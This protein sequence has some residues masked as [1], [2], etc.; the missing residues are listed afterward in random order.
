MLFAFSPLFSSNYILQYFLMIAYMYKR[1][2]GLKKEC[3]GM[4]ER[5]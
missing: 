1:V 2:H 4:K 5:A 3:I